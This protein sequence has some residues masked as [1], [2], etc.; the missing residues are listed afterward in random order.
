MPNMVLFSGSSHYDLSQKVA[1]RLGM[2][3]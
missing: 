1:D 3:L 2:E